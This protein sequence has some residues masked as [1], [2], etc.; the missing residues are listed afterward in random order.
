MHH[1][2]R[3]SYEQGHFVAAAG[4]AGE[5]A[6]SAEERQSEHRKGDP[7]AWCVLDYGPSK[8]EGDDDYFSPRRQWNVDQAKRRAL[9]SLEKRGLIERATYLSRGPAKV[10]AETF[11]PAA[12]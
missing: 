9:R 8:H 12:S 10:P 5:R 4:I 1:L 3:R 2:G 7:V 11:P 6:E